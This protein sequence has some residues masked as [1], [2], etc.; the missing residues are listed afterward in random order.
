MALTGAKSQQILMPYFIGEFDALSRQTVLCTVCFENLYNNIKVIVSQFLQ[1][2]DA[3]KSWSVSP[4]FAT[5]DGCIGQLKLQQVLRRNYGNY[6]QVYKKLAHGVYASL[7][8]IPARI[9]MLMD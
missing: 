3:I 1:N 4:A 9:C 5:T 7:A 2:W 6:T 8:P